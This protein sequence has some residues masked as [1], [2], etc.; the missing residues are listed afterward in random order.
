MPNMMSY[1]GFPGVGY[2]LMRERE[3]RLHVQIIPSIVRVR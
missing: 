2:E 1:L 3:V